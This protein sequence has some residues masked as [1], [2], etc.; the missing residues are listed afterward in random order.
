VG[1]PRS[2][3]FSDKT[4]DYTFYEHERI[5]A[6]MVQPIC[7]RLKFSND[8]KKRIED[9]VRHHMWHYDGWT[10]A[11]VRRWIQ[12]VG[13]DRIEDLYALREADIKGKSG[14]IEPSEFDGLYAMQGHVERVL[15]AGAALSVKDLAINGG[16]LMKKL[17]LKPGRIL[18]EILEALLEEVITDPSVN[19]EPLLLDRARAY[20]AS[21]PQP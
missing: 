19:T 7:E 21:K 4:Q 2:K 8:E 12:R 1:K 10:D 5:G 6:E 17:E 18:G 15:L 3:A 16:V 20:V 9:L 14:V 11:A 13:K